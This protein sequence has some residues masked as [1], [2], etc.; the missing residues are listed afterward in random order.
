MEQ[1]IN[2]INSV[3][4]SN[5][6]III[7]LG[8]NG[9]PSEINSLYKGHL[10]K[11]GKGSTTTYGTNVPFIVEW[12]GKIA[13]QQL[14]GNLIDPSDFLPTLANIANIEKPVNYGPLDG[15]SFYPLLF[16]SEQRLRDWIY[17]NWNP[18]NSKKSFFKVWVQDEN[19]KK[20][21]STYKNLF[22][23]IA[24]DPLELNP[25]SFNQFTLSEIVRKK[26]FDSVLSV[27]H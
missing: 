26:T 22:F 9:T 20:Y 1:L 5:N 25:I 6:T 21:D 4:L 16:G 3:G 18:V 15:I 8:D 17:C 11:G 13:P 7:F 19:Y 14:S 23:N 12:P 2:K 24:A 10:I 27:M